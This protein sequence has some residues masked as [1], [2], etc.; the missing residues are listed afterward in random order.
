MAEIIIKDEALV[1]VADDTIPWIQ[2]ENFVRNNPLPLN[3]ERLWV[4]AVMVTQV[5]TKTAV[6]VDANSQVSGGAYK[7]NGRFYNSSENFA[8]TPYI[9]MLILDIDRVVSAGAGK[10]NMGIGIL[11]FDTDSALEIEYEVRLFKVP[12]K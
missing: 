3:D 12:L 11:N 8:R 10:D 4:Q 2:L 1:H 5:Y 9:T 6:E 7:V